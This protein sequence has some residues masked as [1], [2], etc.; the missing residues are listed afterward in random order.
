MKNKIFLILLFFVFIQCTPKLIP[1]L[2]FN[3]EEPVIVMQDIGKLFNLQCIDCHNEQGLTHLG[4]TSKKEMD[5]SYLLNLDCISCH[6]ADKTLT[7]T[8]EVGKIMRRLSNEMKVDCRYC[9]KET[10]TF[11]SVGETSK[12][13]FV[14][15]F[16]SGR[17]CNYC[18]TERFALKNNAKEEYQAAKKL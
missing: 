14:L 12:E 8:G 13:M 4:M 1:Y 3:K 11:T 7:Q 10:G 2:R 18:H 16:K 9:H 5:I 6:R 15:S 17:Q